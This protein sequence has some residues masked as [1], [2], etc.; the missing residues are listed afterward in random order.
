MV[1]AGKLKLEILLQYY[2]HISFNYWI[3]FLFPA[4]DK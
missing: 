2:P 4:F 3:Q 1:F